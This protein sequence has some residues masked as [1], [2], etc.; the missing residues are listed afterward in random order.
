[1]RGEAPKCYFWENVPGNANVARVDR[2]LNIH[3]SAGLDGNKQG[4]RRGLGAVSRVLPPD[5]SRAPQVLR[6]KTGV[7]RRPLRIFRRDST[8]ERAAS[9]R[10][11]PS[12]SPSPL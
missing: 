12:L 7:R 3:R 2:N 8:N 5:A 4:A 9:S 6:E 10:R 11:L 1:M